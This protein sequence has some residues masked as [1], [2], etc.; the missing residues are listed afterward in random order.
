[1]HHLPKLDH[2]VIGRAMSI[3]RVRTTGEVKEV[4]A[5]ADDSDV[6]ITMVGP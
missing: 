6:S 3:W 4:V 5:E 1:M 2:Q